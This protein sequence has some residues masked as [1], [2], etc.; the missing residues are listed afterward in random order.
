MQYQV[1]AMYITYWLKLLYHFDTRGVSA[2]ILSIF[3][4][5]VLT[6]T[7]QTITETTI[8]KWDPIRH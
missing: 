8:A 3:Y 5:N 2:N 4:L 1:T 6:T 7:A